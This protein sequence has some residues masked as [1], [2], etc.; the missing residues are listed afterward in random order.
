MFL[1]Q[2]LVTLAAIGTVGLRIYTRKSKPQRRDVCDSAFLLMS[3]QGRALFTCQEAESGR[4]D[5]PSVVPTLGHESSWSN[6]QT[7]GEDFINDRDT[8]GLMGP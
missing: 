4:F 1:H 5:V 2:P 6:Q 8:D 3:Y 7:S